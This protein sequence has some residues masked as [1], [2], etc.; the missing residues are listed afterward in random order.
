MLYSVRETA[1]R[2]NEVIQFKHFLSCVRYMQKFIK[3][4][5]LK[6]IDKIVSIAARKQKGK[7]EM[8][9]MLKLNLAQY[10]AN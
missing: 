2:D 8:I 5:Y 3:C 9:K 7:N 6:I 4:S 10:S 1:K